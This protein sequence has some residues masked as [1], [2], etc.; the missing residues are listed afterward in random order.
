LQSS[1][2]E[3]RE[4]AGSANTSSVADTPS[5]QSDVGANESF[6]STPKDNKDNST[7][8]GVVVNPVPSPTGQP[9]TQP[10]RLP[11]G[12]L[13]TEIRAL[14]DQWYSQRGLQKPPPCAISYEMTAAV[15]QTNAG[16]VA[17]FEHKDGEKLEVMLYTLPELQEFK[18]K[19]VM[20]VQGLTKGPFL[21]S[22]LDRQKVVTN[23]V[24]YFVW[25]GIG[26]NDKDGWERDPTVWKCPP[27]IEVGLKT[28]G[29]PDG[30]IVV[31]LNS[32]DSE[33]EHVDN[34]I[35]AE[36]DTQ[37][38]HA[39]EDEW[40]RS[41]EPEPLLTTMPKEIRTLLNRWYSHRGSK[42][43]PPC[44]V[45][46]AKTKYLNT[47]KAGNACAFIHRNRMR[48][49]IS[50]CIL[51]EFANSSFEEKYI[52]LAEG[53]GQDPVIIG[54]VS[55]RSRNPPVPFHI[56]EGLDAVDPDGWEKEAT[57]SQ[58]LSF[59]SGGVEGLKSKV[60]DSGSSDIFENP[61]GGSINYSSE[62]PAQNSLPL[63]TEAASK[64]TG[65][66]TSENVDSDRIADDNPLPDNIKHL[67]NQWCDRAG[68]SC[69]LES[70]PFGTGNHP[71]TLIRTPKG[72][73]VAWEHKDGSK[74]TVSMYPLRGT[75]LKYGAGFRKRVMVA[76]G[77]NL[78]PSI[79]AYV[80]TRSMEKQASYR[81]WKGIEGDKDG[82]EQD[83][84][85]KKIFLTKSA[86]SRKSAPKVKPV[87]VQQRESLSRSQKTETHVKDIKSEPTSRKRKRPDDDLDSS[88]AIGR[89]PS[90]QLRPRD[91]RSSS[92]TRPP[93][94]SVE[95]YI[96][97]N[98][99]FVFYSPGSKT[100]RV[101]LFSACD[102]VQKL[103]AQAVAGDVF[104]DSGGTPL[105]NSRGGKV[106]SIRFGGIR[107]ESETFKNILVVEEDEEDFEALVR[108]IEAKDWWV[109]GKS[110]HLVE[111]SGTVEVR[112]KG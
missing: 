36:G 3:A 89:S 20:V 100:P 23:A 28:L 37:L 19:H 35:K 97:N 31:E 101:R 106:L 83:Y 32:D 53:Q 110:G 59:P 22:F 107:R 52:I 82:F 34:K 109:K 46:Y 102:T 24:P 17:R 71:S 103:F 48:M 49:K 91:R 38:E 21:V 74:L 58:L 108:A 84:S 61:D 39:H 75:E 30:G 4:K 43:P 62:I 6:T 16:N 76:Q 94:L 11:S 25:E 47:S 81:I 57:I 104:D 8:A 65:G 105:K 85:V 12:T 96:Q 78:E 9:Q 7:S 5:F 90:K 70:L 72:R 67:I 87:A 15:H 27:N 42:Q 112:A 92:I 111:G 1:E 14:L 51:P 33:A 86:T 79:I 44:A 69:K 63:H 73:P 13:P 77:P 68:P 2:D 66:P 45:D 55:H 40:Q 60:S 56:W 98:A 50:I 95:K 41:P 26:S 80:Q 10:R 88:M 64:T 29:I 99:V 93:L 18:E 54:F